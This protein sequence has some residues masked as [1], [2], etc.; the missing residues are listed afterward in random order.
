MTLYETC[1]KIIEE[2]QYMK[3]KGCAIDAVTAKA[4]VTVIDA[5]SSENQAEVE[6]IPVPKFISFVWKQVK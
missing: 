1:K 2:H 6:K 5:L 4:V 3:Y